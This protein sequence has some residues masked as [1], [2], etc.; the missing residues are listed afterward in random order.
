MECTLFPQPWP[1]ADASNALHS[2]SQLKLLISGPQDLADTWGKLHFAVTPVRLIREVEEPP[3]NLVGCFPL[4]DGSWEV[5]GQEFEKLTEG[6][7][8][9]WYEGANRWKLLRGITTDGV[10]FS[11]VETVIADTT[12]TWT[13][14]LTMA[15]NPNAREYLMLKIT[16]GKCGFAYHTFFSPDGTNWQKYS[17]AREGGALFYDGDAISVFWSTV[18]KR[19]V[20]VSK[21]LQPW[22]KHFKDHGGTTKS[23]N[24]NSFL[25]RR[26]LMLRSSPDGRHWEPSEDLPD[27]YD[28]HNQKATHPVE[29]LTTPDADDPPDLE[30]YSGNGFWYHDR[31]Y[32]MVLNYAPSP[33]FP[34][35]HA[36][37][38][39]NEWWAS[40]D[41]L[42]W[43]R[44]A[45][46]VNAIE[47]RAEAES[48]SD[49]FRLDMPPMKIDGY[50][51]WRRGRT[52]LGL[53]EDRI[54]GVGARANGEFSLRPFCMPDADLFLNAAAPS[55]E[56]AFAGKQSYVLVAVLDDKGQVI[57]GFEAD[58]CVIQNEDRRDIPLKWGDVSARSLSGRTIRL[59]FYLRSANIYAVTSSP[60]P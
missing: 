35:K 14:H 37:Q 54:S 41:G 22:K 11:N 36:P 32:M 55:P 5:F 56:R 6:A 27:I 51:L 48:K 10:T 3:F 21:C 47:V 59:R 19:Y 57:P 29:W 49:V 4:A 60:Q 43:E 30:F 7:P 9:K 38:L 26:V 33:L 12:G 39:D 17:G 13:S 40:A 15:Y 46:G 2:P 44:P 1:T 53:P 58:K 45:R 34:N 20:L 31:A 28:L 50:L 24:D 8:D 52:L 25:D 16:N 23:L 42:L 18:L